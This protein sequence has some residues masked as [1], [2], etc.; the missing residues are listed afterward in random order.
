MASYV[1]LDVETANADHSSI[2]QLG[3]V[4]VQDDQTVDLV[5]LYVDPE[6]YFDPFHVGIHGI[7]SE[8][9][10]GQPRF[11]EAIAQLRPFLDRIVVTH[12]PFDRIAMARAAEKHRET[13]PEIRWLDCQRVVRRT[14]PQFAK[15][16]Y[17][18]NKL[19][20]HFDIPFQ[21]HDALEDAKA[22]ALVFHRAIQESGISCDDWLI[23]SASSMSGGN[24]TI[25]RSGDPNAP[26][27]G[28]VIVFTGALTIP[29]QQAAEAAARLGF[30][31]ADNVTKKTT[32][33]CV[34]LQ[35]TTQLAGYD[36]SSKH[37]KAE[38][39]IKSG[40]EIAI[41]GEKDFMEL[42]RTLQPSG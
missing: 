17:A 1:V 20:K 22:T 30:D 31:V 9:V 14:W 36:K 24:K 2:C 12:G 4:I 7:T 37:R 21:H 28:E 13:L 3:A 42:V 32:T 40:A 8:K 41:L 27:A 18:L 10:K 26:F 5:S 33:L 38:D 35:D 19:A 6:D 16:G 39:L 11:P 25:E 34:G 15:S 29:R 23:Q